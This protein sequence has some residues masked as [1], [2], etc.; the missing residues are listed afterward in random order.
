MGDGLLA[1]F[2]IAGDAAAVCRAALAAARAFRA[3]VAKLNAAA[4]R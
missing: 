3:E 4:R 1:I 2:P